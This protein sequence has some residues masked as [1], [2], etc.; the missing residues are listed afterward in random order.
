[1]KKLIAFVLVSICVA[2]FAGC[3]STADG[4]A[5]QDSIRNEERS[6]QVN[7]MQNDWGI[8]L[9]TENVT[10]GGLTLVCQQSGGTDVS[11]LLTGS[12]FVIQ[13]HEEAGWA[14]VEYLPQEYD[15]AWTAE[16]WIVQKENTTKWNV[17]WEWLYGEL[18]DSE[19][20]IGK[21]FMCFRGTGDF[22]SEMIY[23]NFEINRN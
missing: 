4:G 3:A 13:K 21:E 9:E 15:V 7:I 11:E 5:L 8:T 12:Y 10:P 23:A 2:T 1:M 18:P 20:R 14:D 17:N 16:A 6:D 19:Y 22:D